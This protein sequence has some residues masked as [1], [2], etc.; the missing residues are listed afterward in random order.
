MANDKWTIVDLKAVKDTRTYGNY[1]RFSCPVCGQKDGHGGR[2]DACINIKTGYGHCFSGSC[3][4]I[5]ITQDKHNELEKAR[6]ENREEWRR[7]NAR[8]RV[9]YHQVDTSKICMGSYPMGIMSYLKKRCI[10]AETAHN[11]HVGY[12]MRKSKEKATD[13]QEVLFLAFQ[14]I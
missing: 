7:L 3:D 2:R 4:A 5:F 12:C 14:F 9:Y 8:K 10:S 1:T 6:R 11:A 13:G